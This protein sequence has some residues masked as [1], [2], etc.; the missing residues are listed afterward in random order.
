MMYSKETPLSEITLQISDD[1]IAHMHGVAEWMYRHA[2]EFGCEDKNKMY[3]L[4]LIHDVGYVFGKSNHEQTGADIIGPGTFLGDLVRNHGLSPKEYM[5][6]HGCSEEEIP[7]ELILLWTA[8]LIVDAKGNTVGF[9]GRL[10]D[11]WDRHGLGSLAYRNCKETME[12]L[13]VRGYPEK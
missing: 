7:R 12:W 10:E 5:E 3:L 9:R 11:I 13:R 8:D 2:E 6:L 4:G 1:R